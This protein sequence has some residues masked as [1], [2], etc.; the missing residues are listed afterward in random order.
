MTNQWL[1][2]QGVPAIEQQWMSIRHSNGTKQKAKAEAK[3]K[4]DLKA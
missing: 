3:A 2:D 4:G 1:S